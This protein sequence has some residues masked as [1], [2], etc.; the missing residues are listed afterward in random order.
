MSPPRIRRSLP[1]SGVPATPGTPGRGLLSGGPGWQHQSPEEA[2]RHGGGAGQL[3]GGGPASPEEVELLHGARER[4]ASGD[5]LGV[6]QMQVARRDWL[7]RNCPTCEA[8]AGK[9]CFDEAPDGGQRRFGGHDE[10]LLL[11]VASREKLEAR[12]RAQRAEGRAPTSRT[13]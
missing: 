13:T 4:L 2:D 1:A 3:K 9:E 7:Q 8:A 10:R 6:L 5:K 12:K 11:V